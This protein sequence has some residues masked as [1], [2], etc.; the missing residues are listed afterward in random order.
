M[1]ATNM[2][3]TP[4][5]K[6]LPSLVAVVVIASLSAS[7]TANQINTKSKTPAQV[8][9][10]L[11]ALLDSRSV[12]LQLA[13][14]TG[15]QSSNST[16]SVPKQVQV[17]K[18]DYSQKSVA[19]LVLA[20][21]AI[22]SEVK[23]ELSS[24]ATL[25]EPKS[26][27]IV[28]DY[29]V[30]DI[31]SVE[32]LDAYQKA[33][34]LTADASGFKPIEETVSASNEVN[35]KLTS[36]I[37]D[38]AEDMLPALP[39]PNANALNKEIEVANSDVE[40]TDVVELEVAASDVEETDVVELEIAASDVE[41]TD[42]VELEVAASDVEE[43]DVVELEIA[44]SDVEETDV[45]ELEVATSDVEETD[46][47]ELQIAASDVEETDVVELEVAASEVE[48][49]DIVELEIAASDAEETDVV[50][51]EIA[52]SDV[53][54]TD[55]VELEIA[56]SDVEET[57]VVELEIAASD[58]EETD[59]VELEIAASDVEETDV[60]E[61]EI[62][63]NEEDASI[64]IME[65]KAPTLLASLSAYT[66]TSPDSIFDDTTLDTPEVPQVT[67]NVG[68]NVNVAI[69]SEGCP[70]NFN[71]VSIPA[72]GKLC[73]IFAADFPASM[74]LFIPQTPEEVVQYYLAS[75]DSFVEPKKIKKRTM[76]KSTDN[77]TTLIISKDGGGTQVDILVKSPIS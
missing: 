58:A 73:Q 24:P 35:S 54:E 39:A 19:E 65:E 72:N 60:V 68:A 2:Q 28:K 46:V 74:I 76:L 26:D 56:A 14:Y 50:E 41:E 3:H 20:G 4:L 11:T 49:T 36:N 29:A 21:L 27:A 31:V 44:A 42:V 48:E 71:K 5:A 77:N 67:D 62:A 43:T 61:L 33:A 55:I 15:K 63:A 1:K 16:R 9:Q 47:V 6:L 37:T 66:Q 45:V 10:A 57:D 30:T 32:E 51:L 75:S 52:A 7:A 8:E 59:V 18:V 25:K 23:Y 34:S 17:K 70:E 12:N 22:T 64:S 13:S 69:R 53:E 40:E 38:L